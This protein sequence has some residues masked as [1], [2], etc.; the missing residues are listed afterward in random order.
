[1]LKP[2]KSF[3]A[4]CCKGFSID[5]TANCGLLWAFFLHFFPSGPLKLCGPA[6]T[7][8]NFLNMARKGSLFWCKA[9]PTVCKFRPSL[10]SNLT[11][12][13]FFQPVLTE[14]LSTNIALMISF[15]FFFFFLHC[16]LFR[17]GCGG[18]SS[19]L[20]RHTSRSSITSIISLGRSP[21]RFHP[22]SSM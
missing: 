3:F 2:L 8:S 15:F 11:T 18:S 6:V 14:V 5:S 16:P 1:M 9:Q 21:M 13:P 17:E 20:S 19:R 12:K 10:S 4:L 7:P 22:R